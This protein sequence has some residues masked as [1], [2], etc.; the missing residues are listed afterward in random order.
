ME[1][2][3]KKLAHLN[4]S[5][6]GWHQA[7]L[8]RR[9]IAVYSEKIP[10]CPTVNEDAAQAWI[11]WALEQADRMDPLVSEKPRSVLDRKLEITRTW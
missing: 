8:I 3:E 9:F 10:D 1:Q 2:E 11:T 7:E 5:V 4:E 6:Q